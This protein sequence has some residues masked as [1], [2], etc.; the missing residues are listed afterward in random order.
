ME[1]K[2]SGNIR[3]ATMNAV[4]T[5]LAYWNKV[6][7]ESL[8]KILKKNLNELLANFWTK[9]KKQN[10]ESYKKSALMGI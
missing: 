10:G 1:G 4:V 3:K 2:N 7:P 5:F 6:K 8:E 9:A